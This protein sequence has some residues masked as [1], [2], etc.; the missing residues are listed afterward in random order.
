[1]SSLKESD[2]YYGS[3]LAKLFS[4]KISIALVEG[5][6]DRQIY[7]LTTN[8]GQFRLFAKYRSESRA[9]ADDLKSWTFHFSD[10]DVKEITSYVEEGYNIKL[11]LVCGDDPLRTSELAVLN[12]Q[13]IQD[14]LLSREKNSLTV[15]RK[16]H[17]RKY[18]I[19]VGGGR[20]N[21]VQIPYSR[22]EDEL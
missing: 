11:A 6:N 17:E 7:D 16:K 22:L 12:A 14:C 1:M 9:G 13:D 5:S 8:K 18:R 20:D 19:H 21:A 10:S 2:F 4:R 15:G 3:V